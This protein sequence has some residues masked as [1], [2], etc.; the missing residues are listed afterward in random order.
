MLCLNLS[1]G[2]HFERRIVDFYTRP[3][4]TGELRSAGGLIFVQKSN[5]VS[6]HITTQWEDPSENVFAMATRGD[7]S[8]AGIVVRPPDYPLGEGQFAS[9]SL[10]QRRPCRQMIPPAS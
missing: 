7:V 9:S 4:D 5:F 2:F 6:L 10:R 3:G 8:Y 1:G